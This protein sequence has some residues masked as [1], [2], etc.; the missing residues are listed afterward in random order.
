M[1]PFGMRDVFIADPLPQYSGGWS[2]S[3]KMQIDNEDEKKKLF[4]IELAKNHPNPF[5]AA[6]AAFENNTTLAL[7]AA[8]NWL[9]DPI[10]I[11]SKD[12]YANTVGVQD[13]LLDKD[14]TA[15][16]LLKIADEKLNGRYLADAKDRLKA[17]ELYAKLRGYMSDVTIDNSKTLINNEIKIVLVKP[18][19]QEATKTI[20]VLPT[21]EENPLASV[22]LVKSA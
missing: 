17:L 9:N 18:Q 22:K 19:H 14:Q 7:W 3:P 5:E 20:D 6:C 1:C 11:G 15:F 13:K 21:S 10:V 8:N 12:L 2:T 4:G 16:K